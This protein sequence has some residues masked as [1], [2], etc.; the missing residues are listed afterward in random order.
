MKLSLMK[1]DIVISVVIPTYNRKRLLRKTIES[2]ANQTYPKSAYEVII[3][4]DGCTDG[5][6]ELVKEMIATFPMHLIYFRQEN[7]GASAARNNGI[8]K[9]K[10]QIIAFI[11]DDCVAFD[12]WLKTIV[13]SLKQNEFEGITGQ[14][15][16]DIKPSFFVHNVILNSGIANGTTNGYMVSHGTCNIAFRRRLF[17]EIGYFN[18]KIK[19]MEDAEF[20][21]RININNKKIL[22]NSSMKVEHI[23]TYVS[24]INNLKNTKVVQYDPY[25]FKIFPKDYKR[26]L[27]SSWRIT[28][29]TYGFW[30]LASMILV[31]L[32]VV[33][34]LNL[35]ADIILLGLSLFMVMYSLQGLH[36]VKKMDIYPSFRISAIDKFLFISFRWL[37]PLSFLIYLLKGSL[38]YKKLLI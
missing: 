4:D 17:D 22:F 13:E 7:K 15:I 37:I 38:K 33:F 28:N 26:L 18:E 12:N 25:L 32:M 9:S 31:Y 20:S 8:K 3:I 19:R 21:W 36:K 24:F 29:Y 34:L 2:L 1:S 6:G 30:R 14:T 5:T 35:S 16:S 11:D 27:I 10:G 23:P